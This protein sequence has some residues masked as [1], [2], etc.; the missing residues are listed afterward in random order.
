MQQYRQEMDKKNQEMENNKNNKYIIQ[1]QI[2][3]KD[4]LKE[5]NKMH[6]KMQ[7]DQRL[8]DLSDYQKYLQE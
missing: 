7:Q 5:V 4:N 8:Q 3:Y 6:K 1:N 2:E